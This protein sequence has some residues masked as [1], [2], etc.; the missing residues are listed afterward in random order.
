MYFQFVGRDGTEYEIETTYYGTSAIYINGE[1]RKL[2]PQTTAD[3]SF[4][5]S[6]K[7]MWVTVW[8]GMEYYHNGY[9][10]QMR[11]PG[12]YD[13]KTYGLCGDMNLIRAD[14]YVLKDGTLVPMPN[15]HGRQISIGTQKSDSSGFRQLDLYTAR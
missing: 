4:K 14:D 3:F 13:S 6:G 12:Y 7:K 2:Y 1:W 10:F 5:K 9:H 11:I 8:H 15:R